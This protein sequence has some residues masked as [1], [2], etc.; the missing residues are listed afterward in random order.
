MTPSKK[1]N[2]GGAHPSSAM[3]NGDPETK[4]WAP[5]PTRR[6]YYS[7]QSQKLGGLDTPEP[8]PEKNRKRASASPGGGADGG[9]AGRGS[10]DGGEASAKSPA[11]KTPPSRGRGL[12]ATSDNSKIKHILAM[13]RVNRTPDMSGDRRQGNVLGLDSPHVPRI[14]SNGGSSPFEFGANSWNS[15]HTPISAAHLITTW[16]TK[17]MNS[18]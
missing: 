7:P 13:K 1:R 9:G 5:R 14:V 8:S 17:I 2:R 3:E 18:W 16:V 10:D 12:N 6:F 11:P 15:G 4:I